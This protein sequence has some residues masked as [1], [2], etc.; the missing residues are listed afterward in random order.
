M[1]NGCTFAAVFAQ[2]GGVE[3]RGGGDESTLKRMRR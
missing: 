3:R 1:K 2:N